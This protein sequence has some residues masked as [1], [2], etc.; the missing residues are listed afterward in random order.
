MGLAGLSLSQ[1]LIPAPERPEFSKI[2]AVIF[3]LNSFFFIYRLG[4]H[5][6]QEGNQSQLLICNR[7]HNRNHDPIGEEME[8]IGVE[9]DADMLSWCRMTH[10]SF[11]KQDM[12]ELIKSGMTLLEAKRTVSESEQEGSMSLIQHDLFEGP[13]PN[14]CK[15]VDIVAAI[16]YSAMGFHDSGRLLAYFKGIFEAL[17]DNGLFLMDTFGGP[18]AKESSEDE[19]GGAFC[20]VKESGELVRFETTWEQE[21]CDSV[22]RVAQ[23][24]LNFSFGDGSRLDGACLF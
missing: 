15:G 10:S 11:V 17:G 18:G 2:A 3:F 21:E 24:S 8:A 7:N 23:C 19:L 9:A 4:R 13:A 12:A 6:I 16:H 22:S 20:R 14:S 5:W 1:S